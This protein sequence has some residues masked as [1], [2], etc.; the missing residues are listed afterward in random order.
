[1]RRQWYYRCCNRF[2]WDSRDRHLQWSLGLRC[3]PRGV[4][5]KIGKKVLL[6]G[7][8]EHRSISADDVFPLFILRGL[9]RKRIAA[10]ISLLDTIVI[11]NIQE[12]VL[13]QIVPNH[14]VF[15]VS[16]H[17]SLGNASSSGILFNVILKH[18]TDVDAFLFMFENRPS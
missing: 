11:W 8:V 13:K 16:D 12:M 6:R 3:F 9:I 17:S 1:M 4:R 7:Y 14:T 15:E 10:L 18:T 2:N 5:D